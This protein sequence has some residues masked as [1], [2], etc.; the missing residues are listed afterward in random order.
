MNNRPSVELEENS[1]PES[2]KLILGH[3]QNEDSAKSS[4]KIVA[5]IVDRELANGRMPA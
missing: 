5:S 4:A 1:L 2:C 3:S